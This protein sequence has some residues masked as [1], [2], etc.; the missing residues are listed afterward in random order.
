MAFALET[1]SEFDKAY[2]KLARKNPEFKKAIDSKAEEILQNP[3][4]F[5]PLRSPLQGLRRVHIMKSFVLLYGIK[6]QEGAVVLVKLKHHD[7]A[8]G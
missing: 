5:K 2:R 8:Y 3:F 7:D 4:R 6:E 1:T